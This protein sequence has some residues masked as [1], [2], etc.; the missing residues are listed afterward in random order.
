[1]FT[2]QIGLVRKTVAEPAR[3]PAAMDSTVDRWFFLLVRWKKAREN[4][5]PVRCCQCYVDGCLQSRTVV[6][7]EICYC[8]AE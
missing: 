1:V 6:V 7:D 4:S 8:D 2:T 3:A 5:Y